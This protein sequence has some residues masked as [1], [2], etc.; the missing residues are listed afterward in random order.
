MYHV[1]RTIYHTLHTVQY[2]PCWDPFVCVVC[3]APALTQG[4][5]V[6]NYDGME[7]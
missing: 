3:W 5:Q 6:P 1:L 7:P 4:V 2:L